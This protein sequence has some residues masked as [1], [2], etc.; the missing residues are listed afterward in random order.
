MPYAVTNGTIAL[1]AYLVAGHLASPIIVVAAVALQLL[2]MLALRRH[3][4]S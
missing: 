2:L 3:L 1:V 4:A